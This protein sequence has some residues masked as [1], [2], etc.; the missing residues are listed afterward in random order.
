[1]ADFHVGDYVHINPEYPDPYLKNASGTIET[2]N[3]IDTTL[4]IMYGV[5]LDGGLTQNPNLKDRLVMIPGNMLIKSKKF[6]FPPS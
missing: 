4:G 3:D 6:K 1:M 2:A 5:R